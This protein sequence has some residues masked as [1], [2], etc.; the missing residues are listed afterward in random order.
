MASSFT[1][2][3]PLLYAAHIR[4]YSLNFYGQDEWSVTK[5]LKLTFGYRFER[6]GN[7]AC[8][9]NCFARMNVQFGATGYQGGANIPYNQ[10]ITTG[11][12]N[13]YAS[14]EPMIA[15]PRLGFA[16][17]PFG[18]S[19]TVLRG[20]VGLFA[21]LF[22]GS[23]ASSVFNNSPNKFSPSVPFGT[24]GFANDPASGAASAAAS[25]TAF[26][27]GFSQGYTMAQ[28][29]AS[30]PKGFT[31]TP[32]GYY[33]PPEL[34]KAPKVLEWSFEIQQPLTPHNVLD[35]TYAGNHGYNQ[36]I[37]NFWPNFYLKNTT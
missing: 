29:Q 19:K 3:Y 13:A 23:V 17:S 2:S 12:H 33:S 9:D 24:V 37:S 1:Q 25:D 26:E 15:E 4:L 8:V 5:S 31:F 14:L 35:V 30:L 36:S 34:F 27:N 28:I 6:D 10:T 11:L 32:P 22:A 21:N 20:G 7:P 18:P 16:W